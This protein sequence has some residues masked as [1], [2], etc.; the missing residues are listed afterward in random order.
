MKLRVQGI[1]YEES[2]LSLIAVIWIV[3]ILTALASEFLYSMQ[4]EVRTARNWSDRVD[5]L[6]AAKSGFET[7]IANLRNDETNYDSLDEDWAEGLAGEINNGTFTTE[8]ADESAKINVNTASEETL[9][10]LIE[11]CMSSSNDEE[12]SDAEITAKSQALA[13]AI[14][15]A[16]PY[17]T[18][19]E[20]AK[21]DG[22]TP[23]L[24][25]GEEASKVKG[26][27]SST[28]AEK[29]EETEGE[30]QTP[31]A[32]VDVTTVY[33]AD[34][35]VANDGTKR[36]NINSADA[37]QIRQ[38][39]NP[40]GQE[41]VTQQEAQAI[42]DYRSQAGGG[43]QSGQQPA[44]QTGQQ[45]GQGGQGGYKGVAQLLDVPAIS[46][47][48][49]D[50]IRDRIAVQDQSSSGQGNQPNQPKKVNINT[51][52]ADELRSLSDRIDNGIADDIIRYRQRNQFDNIEELMQ[53]RAISLDDMKTIVDKVTTSDDATLPGRVNINTA[54]L[55]ILEILPGMDENKANAIIT[56]RKVDSST[57]TATQQ[58]GTGPF[59]NLGQ[60]LDVSGIDENTFRSLVDNVS[61]RSC[62]F[63]IKSEGVTT[64]KKVIQTCT[65]VVDRS[66]DR[67]NIKYWKQE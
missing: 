25:Y 59:D 35:N 62:V 32:L 14:V 27:P 28:S 16:R 54:S 41:V 11:Y 2:G 20:M 15:Q 50:S 1:K 47:Q 36:A 4:L 29:S 17:R 3:T 31:V 43:Q 44:Q 55:E 58:Q 13:A 30:G 64:D 46:Q 26:I 34:K 66:G 67:I 12:L 37:N 40:Q 19:A 18:V 51:A 45:P 53:V 57:T 6:Y 60:L 24:L 10:R 8:I 39:V 49:F 56:R 7:A 33:S 23:E 65:A 63:Y 52:G 22:M 21:A 5:T 42:V 9:T 48:T 61:Y 38:G